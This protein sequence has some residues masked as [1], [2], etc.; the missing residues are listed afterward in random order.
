MAINNSKVVLFILFI[1]K[2]F[3][4]PAK[5]DKKYYIQQINIAFCIKKLVNT[6]QVGITAIFYATL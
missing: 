1:L 2:M 5:I 3:N 4:Y 6:S